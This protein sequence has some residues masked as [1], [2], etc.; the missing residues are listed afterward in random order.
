M[1]EVL[2]LMTRSP[3][4]AST[5]RKSVLKTVLKSMLAMEKSTD[6]VVFD[7]P[8]KGDEACRGAY[9]G[10]PGRA[11]VIY[12]IF[13]YWIFGIKSLNECM[14]W[15]PVICK[16]LEG[17]IKN[18]DFVYVDMVR[19]WQYVKG[20]HK[21][22]HVDL[23]DMLSERYRFYSEEGGVSGGD[24]LGYAS[25]NY[26][27]VAKFIPV[28]LL[29]LMLARESKILRALEINIANEAKTVSLV[30]Q[31]EA[32]RLSV[33]SGVRVYSIPMAV[34]VSGQVIRK[35][36][37][38]GVKLVFVGGANYAPNAKSL[39]Y[40]KDKISPLAYSSL[41]NYSIHHVGVPLEC[42]SDESKNLVSEGYV[43]DL[44]EYLSS[45]D[46]LLA[47]ILSGTGIK[48]KIIEAMGA[49]LPVITT[50]KGVEGLAVNHLEHCYVAETPAEFI[51]GVRYF[52]VKEN[53]EYCS[54]KA[55]RYVSENFSQHVLIEKWRGI[56]NG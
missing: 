20:K 27:F 7:S 31:L 26:S 46:A 55:R 3:G 56:I 44:Q 39:K 21:N 19:L 5:G 48:T 9:L 41:D 52:S 13:R 30:S 6:L 11:R 12:N 49:G 43:D 10:R 1:A 2:L 23:D 14:Y 35:G 53:S 34:K 18:S 32:D 50:P 37:M 22:V 36:N 51:D 54:E 24:V 38:N 40:I 17:Y 29:R 47:P 33:L 28:S 25:E 45:C 16:A 8:V 15:S 4:G 42:F